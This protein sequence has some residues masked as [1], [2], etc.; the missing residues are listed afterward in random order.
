M[1]MLFSHEARKRQ[2]GDLLC[3]R[4]S[5]ITCDELLPPLLNFALDTLNELEKID[6]CFDLS[7][8]ETLDSSGVDVLIRDIRLAFSLAIRCLHQI[9][10]ADEHA[11]ATT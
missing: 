10:T 9:R 6:C 3:N 5:P 2:L 4:T 1:S 11:H 7:H 8:S